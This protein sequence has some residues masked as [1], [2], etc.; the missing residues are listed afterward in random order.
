MNKEKRYVIGVD[1]GTDSCR[2]LVVDARDGK[3]IASSVCCYPRWK[4]GLYCDPRSDRYR[5]HPD[6]KSVV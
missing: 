1:F 2:A 5:Q 6:R 4:E 3:R